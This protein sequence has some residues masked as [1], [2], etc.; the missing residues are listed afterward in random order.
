MMLDVILVKVA[1][2]LSFV[3][4]SYVFAFLPLTFSKLSPR[5]FKSIISYGN[6]FAGGV[7][8]AIGIT[9]LLGESKDLVEDED[10]ANVNVM[11]IMCMGGFLFVFFI[12]KVMM[13]AHSFD[14]MYAKT[15]ED[16]KL[17]QQQQGDGQ[18]QPVEVV[19]DPASRAKSDFLVIVLMLV[20]SVNGVVSGVAMGMGDNMNTTVP[21]FI[22]MLVHEW[23]E[24][25]ALGMSMVK[26]ELDRWRMFKYVTIYA[27]SEPL[28]VVLGMIGLLVFPA[29]SVPLFQ[30]IVLAFASGTFIYIAAVD[31]LPQE[32]EVMNGEGWRTKFPKYLAWVGGAVAMCVMAL[33]FDYYGLDDKF[34]SDSSSSGER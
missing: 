23:L 11:E 6:A 24:A 10:F 27:A 22:G 31:I 17:L 4:V 13:D 5:V 2:I 25:L 18:Q 30:A 20:L 7:F 26:A 8:L 19:A 29:H 15:A 28:G 32:F 14:A 12:E 3:I 21:L 33:L 1:V 9:H 34:D 16:A